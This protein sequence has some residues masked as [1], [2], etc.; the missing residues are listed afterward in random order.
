LLAVPLFHVARVYSRKQLMNGESGDFIAQ[1]AQNGFNERRS[2]D[3][4]V[5][6]EPNFMPGSGGTT[7]FSPY[8][9]DR[10]VPLLFVGPGIKRGDFLNS[11]TVN[12]VAPTLANML[13]IEA[14]SG[15]SGRV[16]SEMLQ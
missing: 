5:V 10:H 9:Y 3:F 1:A 7:H 16:L 12:D 8:G 15:A 14:P 4:S 2:G 13:E 11:V 6:F